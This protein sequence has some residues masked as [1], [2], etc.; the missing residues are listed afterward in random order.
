[1]SWYT[2]AHQHWNSRPLVTRLTAL[3]ALLLTL[4]ISIS[5]I[6]MLSLLQR[7][8]VA[9][10]DEQLA[11]AAETIENQEVKTS[12]TTLVGGTGA[13]TSYYL[14]YERVGAE[15]AQDV[16]YSNIIYTAGKPKIPAMFPHR[17]AI[18][19]GARSQPVTIS[20]T[21]IGLDWRAMA[22]AVDEENTGTAQTIITI[23]LPL[24]DIQQTIRTASVYFSFLGMTIIIL[25]GM[26]GSYMVRHALTGLR[27]IEATAGKIAA[28]D[29][30]QRIPPEPPTTEV[31]SLARSLNIM[32][33]QVEQSFEAR[34]E[35]EQKI[36][37]FVSDASHELRTPLAA[38]R[39]YGELY[40][41]GGVP[42]ERTAEVMGRIHGEATRMG[43]LVDDLLTLA[44]LDEGRAL[45]YADLDLVTMT[46]HA[47]FDMRALDPS[48]VV[49]V[50]GLNNQERP[51]KLTV[52]AD[53]DRLQQ[54]FTNL[55]G[56]IARYT[57]KG[58]PV[59]LLLGIENGNAVVEFRDHGP[60]ISTQDRQRVFE[61]FYRAEDSRARS[62]GGSGLGLSIVASI[63]QAHHGSAELSRTDGGG[64]TVT[65]R[66]PLHIPD[67]LRPSGGDTAN[68]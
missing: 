6:V 39:G 1:M 18:T 67:A 2:K 51:E 56:N 42:E 54:V 27:N 37:R 38:I 11:S 5:S 25:G 23:A 3:V 9:Q 52:Q 22:I 8:L 13:P 7:H 61:R 58:S 28:G 44:R 19:P 63:L 35:S 26:V 16:Y 31:G 50:L 10:V 47:A 24:N 29:L 21:I 59:E 41:M 46:E 55:V 53:K 65:M 36:R 17:D 33:S 60:G 34:Q 66:L 30:T 57:P 64:L 45:D 20:S 62:L 14:R 12:L 40:A 15:T 49:T 43:A 48:R 32:L 68:N 4:G